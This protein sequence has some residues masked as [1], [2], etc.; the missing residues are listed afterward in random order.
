MR[1]R[2][3]KQRERDRKRYAV[4]PARKATQ[5][6]QAKAWAEKNRERSNAIKSEWRRRHLIK[7]RSH[8]KV[9]YALRVG[10]LVREPCEICGEV[11]VEAHHDDYKKPL[12][13]RWLCKKHHKEHHR[14]ERARARAQ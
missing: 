7:R 14:L 12:T 10:T 2:T 1:V 11:D 6:A 13:V 3:D 4:D 9:Q 5:I 8:L